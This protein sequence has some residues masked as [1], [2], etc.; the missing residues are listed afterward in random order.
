MNDKSLYLILT[1]LSLSDLI[2]LLFQ[3]RTFKWPD[4]TG[5]FACT[6]TNFVLT[7]L[8]TKFKIVKKKK[9]GCF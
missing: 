4:V 8:L 6:K 5:V 2:A 9:G 1:C 7:I 3:K